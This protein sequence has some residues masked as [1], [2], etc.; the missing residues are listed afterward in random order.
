MQGIFS[1]GQWQRTPPLK[2]ISPQPEIFDKLKAYE[3]KIKELTKATIRCIELDQK[4][5]NGQ[6]ILTGKPSKG[7]VVF[8]IAY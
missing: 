6:C 7:R 3:D 4:E 2:S 5:E 8:A 1:V